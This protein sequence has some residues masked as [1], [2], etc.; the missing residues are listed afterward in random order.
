MSYTV[1]GDTVT[2]AY[3]DDGIRVS[4]NVAGTIHEYMLDGSR[5]I[6]EIVK[7]ASGVE[8]YRLTYLY[9]EQDGLP[10]GMQ[11]RTPSMG[12]NVWYTY[13]FEKNLQIN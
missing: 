11:Y 1:G 12:K 2:Y 9:D 8:Q 10:V 6:G 13:W 7:N 4:Q 3:N 5:I